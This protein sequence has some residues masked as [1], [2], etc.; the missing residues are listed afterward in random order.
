MRSVEDRAAQEPGGAITYG[1][2]DNPDNL[3]GTDL[4]SAQLGHNIA[5]LADQTSLGRRIISIGTEAGRE[6]YPGV[7]S[8]SYSIELWFLESIGYP[9][10]HEGTH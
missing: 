2:F 10:T 6:N 8:D 9:I 3:T 1:G 4:K 5:W 7:T